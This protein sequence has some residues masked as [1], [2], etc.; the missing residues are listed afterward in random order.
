MPLLALLVD[1]RH[2]AAYGSVYAIVQLSVCLAYGLGKTMEYCFK[3]PRFAL[4]SAFLT[5]CCCIRLGSDI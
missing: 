4:S 5:I 3:S 2:V 1:K